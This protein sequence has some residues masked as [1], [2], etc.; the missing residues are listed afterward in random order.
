MEVNSKAPPLRMLGVDVRAT[1]P[2]GSHH[3]GTIL[4]D[5]DMHRMGKVQELKWQH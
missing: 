4:D 3:P 1:N 5:S 2:D